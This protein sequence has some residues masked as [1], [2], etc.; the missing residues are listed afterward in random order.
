LIS[1][2]I[3]GTDQMVVVVV[4]E[5]LESWNFSDACKGQGFDQNSGAAMLTEAINQSMLH[6]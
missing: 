6:L 2:T 4:V 3:G 5:R 1:A